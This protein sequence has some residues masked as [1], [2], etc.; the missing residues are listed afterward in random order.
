MQYPALI[1]DKAK[2]KHNTKVL[3]EMAG[4]Y[5]IRI[6]GVTKVF[7][8]LPE[9]SEAIVEAGAYALADA[10]LEN[11]AKL[12]DIN[13]PKI[14]LRIPM[15]SQVEQVVEYSDI[16]LNSELR[17]IRAL[18]EAAEHKNK[19]HRIIMMIDL[20]DLR[21]GVWYE[22][23]VELAGE[24]L[25]LEN[26]KLIGI[27]TNLT[28]YGGVIPSKDNLSQ[29][30]DIAEAIESK[31]GIKL[32]VISGGNSSSLHLLQQNQ[33]PDRVNQLRLGEAILLGTETAYGERIENT[34]G[35]AFTFAAEIVELK[36]KP[37]V[38]IGEIGMDAFGGKPVFEDKGLIK[39]A[40]LAAGRQDVKHEGLT[41]RDKDIAILGASSDHMILDLTQSKTSYK[42]GDI[43]E[44][45]V[46]YGALLAAATSEYVNKSIK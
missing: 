20:G 30:V 31:Y 5:G 28:C 13:V 24:I 16:S 25:K 37:S 36:E 10:R 15:Y 1:I 34:Y 35:D 43:I 39:R 23:A 29:L 22:N 18:N 40:I 19:T 2:V 41:P 33:M 9:V 14:L 27:G 4:K 17:V 8:A 6:A 32:D 42:V 44:F 46:S 26:I 12:K 21:E 45:D 38:P 7:C 3:A 11:L